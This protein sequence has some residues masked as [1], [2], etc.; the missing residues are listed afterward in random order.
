M[1]VEYNEGK[2]VTAWDRITD[3]LVI[4]YGGSGAAAAITANDHGA[5]V[6]ILEKMDTPGGTTAISG[7]GFLGP[8][9]PEEAFSY[10]KAIFQLSHASYQEEMLR[11]FATNLMD[12]KKWIESLGAE[13]S[14]YGHAAYPN[15]P[16][17]G[18]INKC[19]VKGS[20]SGAKNLW[21]LLST[22]VSSRNI[23]VLLKTPAL[24]LIT[25]DNREVIGVKAMHTGKEVKIR[26]NRAVILSC[27][28]FESNE[29]MKRN[30]LKGFPIFSL[31]NQGNT[32]DGIKMA[33][34]VGADLWH[35][36]GLSCSLGVKVQEFE[37]PFAALF[38][39]SKYKALT[40]VSAPV[41]YIYVDKLGKRF[42]NELGIEVHSWNL[43]LDYY[44]NERLEYLRIPIYA[45]FDE[46]TRKQ[47]PVAMAGMG[48]NRELYQWSPKN[49]K[50][51][52][53][54]W[55]IKAESLEGLARQL[56][57]PPDSL[58]G[59]IQQYN[60]YCTNK[61]DPEFSRPSN[62]LIAL[63]SPPYYALTL[64]PCLLNT[65]GGP[66]RNVQA[67]IVDPWGQPIP[68]LYSAGELGSLWGTIYQGAGNIGEC[69]VFGRIAGQNAASEKPW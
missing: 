60:S 48:A 15:L 46:K 41:R 14:V 19:L 62:S 56:D 52:E 39:L 67:Q 57:L 45:I 22:N 24:K 68:R 32:G 61:N 10:I 23:E 30:F 66:R 9:D 18:S 35:M 26:A 34:E 55:I 21:D 5:K 16:G 37:T 7:G 8:S 47:G 33:M 4:G 44:D 29:E 40:G 1:T 6:L 43:A 59:T 20:G 51:I 3:V 17:A 38:P 53:K 49:E 36:N 31:A 2:G 27:G 65:Q 12:N 28:G 54:G 69:F 50:E 63:D 13:T 58:L 25:I 42:V 64:Y 11:I